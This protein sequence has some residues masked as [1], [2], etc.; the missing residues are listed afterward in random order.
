MHKN[1]YLIA[2]AA[3]L[4]AASGGAVASPLADWPHVDSAVRPDA[5]LEA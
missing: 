3:L 1:I 4:G 2:A 5:K